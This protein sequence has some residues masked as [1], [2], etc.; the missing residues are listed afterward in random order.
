M[1]NGNRARLIYLHALTPVHSGTGQVAA[2]IDLP[3]A[4]EKAT[5]L[6]VIPASSLKGVLRD[7]L[8]RLGKADEAWINT[9]FGVADKAGALCLGDQRIFCLA[10]RSYFGTFGYITS[11][12]VL[13]RL[14]RD[15]RALGLSPPIPDNIPSVEDAD[16]QLII[17][18]PQNG[19]ALAH[20]KK[21]YLEDLDLNAQWSEYAHEV[22]RKI[23]S[24]LFSDAQDS[25]V[26]RFGIVSDEVFNFLCETAT[27][28][29]ARVALNEDTKTVRKG[30]LWYEE[31]VPAETLF[32]GPVLVADHYEGDPTKLW[33][34][35]NDVA[36][37]QIGGKSTVGRGLCRVVLSGQ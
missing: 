3:I 21:V 37:V 12:L 34:H 26:K 29:V 25:F 23:A 33:K 2:V 18:V 4:R 30:G 9:A 11:P 16:Q 13:K 35:L 31:A 22:A 36:L 7:T 15:A 1:K 6:P 27:E 32:C 19:S 8:L 28:I 20:D 24:T 5:G 14:A 10:V 17:L